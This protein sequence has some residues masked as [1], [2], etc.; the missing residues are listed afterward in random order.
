M[1]AEIKSALG[2]ETELIEGT[3]GIFDVVADGRMIFSK[4][5]EQRFPELE[6]IIGALRALSAA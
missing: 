5:A 4:H 1:A 2:L 3:N 6:E